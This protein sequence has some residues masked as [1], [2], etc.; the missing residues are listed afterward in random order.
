M[1]G[2]GRGTVP[3]APEPGALLE[4]SLASRRLKTILGAHITQQ[5]H[6]TGL[7]IWDHSQIIYLL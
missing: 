1:E 7:G 6:S 5:I 2:G 3:I 4:S